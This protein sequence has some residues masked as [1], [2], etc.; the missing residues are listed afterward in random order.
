MPRGGQLARQW[1]LLQLI[2]RPAGVTV[3]DAAAELDCVVRTIWRDLRVLQDAGFPIYDDRAPN[4]QQGLWRVS[5]EFKQ[6]LPLKLSLAELAALLMSRQLLAPAGASLLG[7]AVTSAFDKITGVLSRDALQVIDRMRDTVGVRA[8]GAKLQLPVTEH[9]PAVQDALVEHRGLRI[10]YYSFQR[11]E[12][13]KREVDPYHLT[14]FNGG[15]YLVGYCHLRRAIRVFAMER[16]R[17]LDV[18]SRR[19]TLP[20]GFDP[21]KYLAGAL[22]II[23]GDL[24]TVKV[25]FATKLARYIRERLWH[26]SQKFRDLTDGRLELT[27]HVADTLE[28]RRWILG[29]GVEAEVIEPAAMREALRQE[30][31]ALADRLA[32]QR[33]PLAAAAGAARAQQRSVRRSPYRK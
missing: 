33:K 4:G 8:F 9:L 16:I 6:K 22:G 11:D 31:A 5:E 26:P 30:A 24:V 20:V 17:G 32:P 27:L 28:V 21:E 7:P 2:D 1:R 10:R 23:S 19:F 15:L 29:Y 18:L 14:Y 25:V 12:E 3:A 13:T